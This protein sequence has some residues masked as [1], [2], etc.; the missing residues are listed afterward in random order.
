MEKLRLWAMERLATW[1]VWELV[2]CLLASVVI[3]FVTIN[4][5]ITNFMNY[6]SS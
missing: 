3:W 4:S 6:D 1:I 5:P 2:V